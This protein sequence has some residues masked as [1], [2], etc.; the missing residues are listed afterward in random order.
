MNST[1]KVGILITVV[2]V[3]FFLVYP[4]LAQ[5][6]LFQ[7][8]FQTKVAYYTYINPLPKDHPLTPHGQVFD[9]ICRT[10]DAF[11]PTH[12]I[13]QLRRDIELTLNMVTPVLADTRLTPV[14]L[15]NVRGRSKENPLKME[16]LA[17]F[18]VHAPHRL[19]HV[20]YLH[21]G[22]YVCGSIRSHRGFASVLTHRVR[23]RVL[24][25]DYALGPEYDLAQALEDAVAAYRYLL[26]SGVNANQ[27]FIAGDSAGG[28]LTA[29]LL[30]ELREL[31]EQMPAGAILYS[32]LLDLNLSLPSWQTNAATDAIVSYGTKDII[33]MATRDD[34]ALI[35]KFTFIHRTDFSELPPQCVFV[36]TSEVLYDDSVV[37][38]KAAKAANAKIT[39]YEYENQP[40]V[41]PVF[42]GSLPEVD[43]SIVK[44][45][46][47]IKRHFV[48][49]PAWQ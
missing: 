28:G 15:D 29:A 47:F 26:E 31:G 38:T 16:W 18:G 49:P 41:F 35:E 32:P 23:S 8:V 33:K 9:D 13:D 5:F 24:M 44:T 10:A 11:N 48:E 12:G 4:D 40:H 17:P 3:G 2:S 30:F 27:V 14:E 37:Y 42:V 45:V 46:R 36:S 6:L 22:G 39:L 21:G 25:V 7:G 20:L 34:P 19:P 43:D 1:I